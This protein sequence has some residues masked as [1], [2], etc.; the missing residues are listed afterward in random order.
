MC[1]GYAQRVVFKNP[2]GLLGAY[3]PP[4]NHN[5]Q[6]EQ[7]MGV[8]L[9]NGHGLLPAQQAAAAAQ[10]PMLAPRPIDS[11]SMGYQSSSSE[12]L[13][14]TD[15]SQF[16]YP[17]PLTQAPSN[18]WP[19]QGYAQAPRRA[20]PNQIGD[21]EP[22]DDLYQEVS[23]DP[24][25][26]IFAPYV[27]FLQMAPR[28]N[29]LH[30]Q[31]PELSPQVGTLGDIVLHP[32]P[33]ALYLDNEAGDFY[34]VD[35]DDEMTDQVQA[36]GFNQLSLIMAS[37]SHNDG[38]HRSFTTHLNE[39]NILATY[40]PTMG[41]SPLNNPRTARIFAHFIHATGPSLSIFERHQT[42]ASIVL[43]ASVPPSQQGLWTY[44]L[45]LKALEDRALL[46]AVLAVSSLHIA[47]LQQ[48]STTVSLKHYHY[49]LKRIGHAVGLPLRRKQIGTL[50]A[51][52]LL[53]YYE[54]IAA[55][56]TKWNS[57]LAG[58]AQLIKEIDFASTTQSL[59]AQRRR[60]SER[61]RQMEWSNPSMTFY[62]FGSDVSEDDPF[63]EKESSVDEGL[64]SMIMG[65]AINLDEF[66][67]VEEGHTAIPKR[68]SRKDIETFRIQ[69][70]LYW[71]FN[72][73]DLFHSLVSGEKLL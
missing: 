58:A 61:R 62:T 28:P 31:H 49:A 63:A 50:A 13:H 36:E 64:I 71:W 2:L 51:T 17:V 12:A 19:G 25:K 52:E 26:F 22:D 11:A 42:D 47:Y 46:Q 33:Q 4:Q 35:S 32:H 15:L 45:A 3:G 24:W 44:T 48:V 27:Y 57:H 29:A 38:R 16:Q 66:G 7:Q 53:A 39:P 18:F 14:N 68:F 65:R 30:Q 67:H 34:D 69:C 73:Q 8:P 5:P 60:I 72:K 55:D 54:V 9:P 70:D 6:V 40:Q 1:E 23:N 56:H 37:A 59:R 20:A 21:E 43:G 41:S 10:Y